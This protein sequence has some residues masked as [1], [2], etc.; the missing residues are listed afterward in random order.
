MMM[1]WGSGDGV[2]TVHTDSLVTILKMIGDS[3]GTDAGAPG[4]RRDV[5]GGEHKITETKLRV[6]KK[7][8]K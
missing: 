3:V 5:G 2:S 4:H 6:G 1:H 8:V 7:I